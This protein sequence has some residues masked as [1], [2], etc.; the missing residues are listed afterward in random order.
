MR[1]DEKYALEALASKY[2]GEFIAGDDPP[3]GY[4]VRH[5]SK[6]AV[7]VSRLIEHVTS[8]EGITRPRHADNA[9]VF[10]LIE[11]I[12]SEL[13]KDIPFGKYVLLIVYTPVNDVRKTKREL[14]AKIIE[15]LSSEVTKAE[16]DIRSNSISI[17]VYDGCR[18]SGKKV[19]GALP[20]KNSS[21]DIGENVSYILS[22]RIRDKESKRKDLD[23]TDEYWLALINEYWIADENSYR[24]SY[25]SL[26]IAHGFDKI[27]LI[28]DQQDVHEIYRKI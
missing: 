19:I 3:D 23:G 6:V 7:E 17:S 11:D 15:M 27:L 8:D 12:D 14:V 20:S 16:V 13:R 26:D 10:K 9:P 25:N 1:P 2:G 4:L 24:A 5:E 28:N 18:E 21:A 22:S